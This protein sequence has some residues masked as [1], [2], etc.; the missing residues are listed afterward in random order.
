M[1][2]GRSY[3]HLERLL[4]PTPRWNE[5]E[6]PQ[7]SY[8]LRNGSLKLLRWRLRRS[9]SANDSIDTRPQSL[10]RLH[11]ATVQEKD[12]PGKFLRRACGRIVSHMPRYESRFEHSFEN[13]E[14]KI[15]MP[16]LCNG[17]A[18]GRMFNV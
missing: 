13:R 18:A 5:A 1:P 17:G 11:S 12:I 7:R 10:S 15:P 14:S 6:E 9:F 8:S 4:L 2:L 3:L 16:A